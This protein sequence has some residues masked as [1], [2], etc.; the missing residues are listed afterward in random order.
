MSKHMHF[1][2]PQPLASP[3][4]FEVAILS[5]LGLLD[6]G[7]SLQEDAILEAVGSGLE[8]AGLQ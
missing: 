4:W 2:Q 5:R 3:D 6:L 1:H 7:P 8:G